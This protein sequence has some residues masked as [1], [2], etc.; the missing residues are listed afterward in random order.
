MNGNPF[1]LWYCNIANTISVRYGNHSM[2]AWDFWVRLN[3]INMAILYK[4]AMHVLRVH[5]YV[6]EYLP[7]SI[8]QYC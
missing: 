2:L 6:L 5:V 8:A 7:A 1:Y 3:N 4:I